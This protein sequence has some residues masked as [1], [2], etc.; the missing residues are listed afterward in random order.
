[1][2]VIGPPAIQLNRP[3]GPSTVRRQLLTEAVMLLNCVETPW[4]NAL[5]ATMA[6]IAMR[7]SSRAYSTIEAPRSRLSRARSQAIVTV[8]VPSMTLLLLVL[9]GVQRAGAGVPVWAAGTGHPAKD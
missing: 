1:M 4:P 5:T 3:I 7:P 8:R 9:L 2:M 6:M